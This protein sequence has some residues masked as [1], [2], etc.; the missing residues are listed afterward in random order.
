[1]ADLNTSLNSVPDDVSLYFGM[2]RAGEQIEAIGNSN[3]WAKLTQ[4]PAVQLGWAMFQMQ[5]ADSD[6]P[7]GKAAAML[8]DAQ[9]KDV[10]ALLADMFDDEAFIYADHSLVDSLGLLQKFQRLGQMQ[11]IQDA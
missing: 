3:A 7:A 9:V 4:S 8:E 6:T 1:M 10:L 2:F 11:N 5:S